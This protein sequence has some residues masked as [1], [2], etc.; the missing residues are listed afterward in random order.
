MD[1]TYLRSTAFYSANTLQTGHIYEESF[2]AA[3]QVPHRDREE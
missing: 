3:G 1:V 2:E